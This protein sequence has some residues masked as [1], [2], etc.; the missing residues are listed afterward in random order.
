MLD[1]EVDGTL[2]CQATHHTHF[3]KHADVVLTLHNGEAVD[4]IAGADAVEG[5]EP[6]A[7]ID[8]LSAG[9]LVEASQ[10]ASSGSDD[11]QSGKAVIAVE[12]RMSG[13][14]ALH[15]YAKY[16]MHTEYSNERV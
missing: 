10:A 2:F 3:A 5:S 9:A 14:I 4:G 1:Y 12:H 11:Q 6:R 15:I 8:D 13:A 16:D 7:S